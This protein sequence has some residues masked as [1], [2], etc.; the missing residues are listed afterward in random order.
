M[1]VLQNKL[2]QQVL[3]IEAAGVS[4]GN[5]PSQYPDQGIQSV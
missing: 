1:N 5:K 4:I 3:Q 2:Q